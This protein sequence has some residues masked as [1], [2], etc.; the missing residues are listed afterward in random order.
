LLSLYEKVT[1]LEAFKKNV[2]LLFMYF[3]NA[4]FSRIRKE[5]TDGSLNITDVGFKT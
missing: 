4:L 3:Y 5:Q 2:T 1:L